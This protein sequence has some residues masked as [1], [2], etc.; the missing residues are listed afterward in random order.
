[1][2]AFGRRILVL[3]PHPDDEVVGPAALIGRA[4]TAGAKVWL[5]HMTTGVPGAETLWPWQRATHQ[6]KVERRR[7]EAAAV[8]A[9][10]GCEIAGFSDRPTRSLRKNLM[11][12]REE[13]ARFLV[14]LEIDVVWVPA[15]E[16]GHSDHD[17]ANVLASTILALLSVFEFAEYNFSNGKV[18]S[19]K[20]ISENGSEMA[21]TLNAEE[22]AE[23]QRLLSLYPSETGNLS[24][25]Q[26]A[27]EVIRP[28]KTYDYSKPPHAGRMFYQRFQ[29]VPFRHPR[30]DWTTPKQVS[31]DAMAF[32]GA[33]ASID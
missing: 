18:S 19:Q 16:G 31:T 9:A 23:K 28:L 11:T 17:S 6:D 26:Q 32:L 15:Y 24:Y 14:E 20:F 7:S 13:L 2:E 5:W 12:A 1:M 21:I 33:I 30:I 3:S 22:V 10:M 8:S 4:R 25:V 29:W 27:R